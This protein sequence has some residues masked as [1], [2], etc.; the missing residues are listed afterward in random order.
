[1][2][3][4][5]V[6]RDKGAGCTFLGKGIVGRPEMGVVAECREVTF[7]EWDFMEQEW[8]NCEVKKLLYRTDTGYVFD[9]DDIR[10]PDA[11]LEIEQYAPNCGRRHLVSTELIR[12]RD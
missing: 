7:D 11:R 9:D 3:N 5:D 8:K 6:K 4:L 10:G 12:W 1:M 2:M